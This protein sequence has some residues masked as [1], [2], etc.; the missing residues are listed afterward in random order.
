MID[1]RPPFL[2][3]LLVVGVLSVQG[4]AHYRV[5]VPEPTPATDY[6]TAT[7]NAYFWGAI[8]ET[9]PAENC[10]DNSLDEVR[11][12]QTFPHVLATVLTL[13]IWMPLEVEWRCAKR[14]QSEGTG[15]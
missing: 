3:A 12:R 5:V 1:A 2:V 14:P 13:G 6:E 9:L 10:V 4:C 15:F 7:M 11:V 8:E